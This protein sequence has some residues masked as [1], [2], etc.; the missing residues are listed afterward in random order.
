VSRSRSV[1]GND[2]FVGDD[3]FSEKAES[4]DNEIQRATESCIPCGDVSTDGMAMADS[5]VTL[6]G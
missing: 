4:N 2:Q 1:A 6:R 3:T 5:L